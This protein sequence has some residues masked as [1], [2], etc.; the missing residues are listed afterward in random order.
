MS[1]SYWNI[2]TARESANAVARFR[3][4]LHEEATEQ[5][6]HTWQNMYKN[7]PVFR[8]I[9]VIFPVISTSNFFG[10]C[11]GKRRGFEPYVSILCA[12]N[13]T[14]KHF[15]KKPHVKDMCVE[16]TGDVHFP[17]YGETSIHAIWVIYYITVYDLP[18]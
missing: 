17:Q 3:H 1:S 18:S 15:I 4:F 8:T 5:I 12:D 10:N 6:P 11:L 2:L 14:C 9:H 7:G 16:A 13:V